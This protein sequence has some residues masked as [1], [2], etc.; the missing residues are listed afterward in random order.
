MRKLLLILLG[1]IVIGF[2]IWL[3]YYYY[4]E[5]TD[6]E[7]Y[8][9]RIPERVISAVLAVDEILVGLGMPDN[10]VAIHRISLDPE[11]SNIVDAA[12]EIKHHISHDIEQII[13]LQP[14]LVFISSYSDPA[15]QEALKDYNIPYVVF[16]HFTDW[17]DISKMIIMVG[18]KVGKESGAHRMVQQGTQRLE[19][20]LS[21]AQA[22]SEEKPRLLFY[23][24]DGYCPGSGT[25][26]N[27]L[28]HYVNAVNIAAQQGIEG[29]GTID[30]EILL[31]WNPD[32]IV[33]QFKD[34]DHIDLSILREHPV[35]KNLEAVKNNRII[36]MPTRLV[37]TASQFFVDAVELLA[38]KL[39]AYQ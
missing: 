32:Y 17:D 4:F 39:Y 3:S 2:F 27:S 37:S 20:V 22:A 6:Q 29:H 33:L 30:D 21:D 36:V 35:L 16:T 19:A 31:T 14:D 24:P 7:N 9:E 8:E 18:E 28:C 11:F 15:L 5:Q 10:V 38:T 13:S 25:T 26:F 1:I 12:E 23:S 34:Y